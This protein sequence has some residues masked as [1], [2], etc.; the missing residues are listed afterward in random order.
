M[1]REQPSNESLGFVVGP[2]LEF[3][4]FDSGLGEYLSAKFEPSRGITANLFNANKLRQFEQGEFVPRTVD[5]EGNEVGG[6]FQAPLKVLKAEALE[7][8]SKSGVAV[9]VGEDGIAEQALE[10][11]IQRRREDLL[12]QSTI[13]RY[14][15]GLG[16]KSLG[17]SAAFLG[18]A[19]DPLNVAAAF[20][21]IVGPARYSA[22][23]ARAGSGLGARAAVR[24]GVGA[25]EGAVGVAALEPLQYGAAARLQDDYTLADSLA[26]IAFGTFLGAGLHS[27]G[28]AIFDA[29]KG[30]AKLG[31]PE[32]TVIAE[33]TVPLTTNAGFRARPTQTLD[34][35]VAAS[36]R[37]DVELEPVRPTTTVQLDPRVAT[38]GSEVIPRA[39]TVERTVEPAELRLPET[40]TVA[41]VAALQRVDTPELKRA[42][43]TRLLPEAERTTT[44]TQFAEDIRNGGEP[45][46]INQRIARALKRVDEID[47][48]LPRRQLPETRAKLTAERTEL[49]NEVQSAGRRLAEL[50]VDPY[51][52]PTILERVSDETK[53]STLRAAI[54]Q[55][56]SGKPIDVEAIVKQAPTAGYRSDPVEIQAFFDRQSSPTILRSEQEEASIYGALRLKE[57]EP[58]ASLP[59]AQKFG[60]DGEADA[61]EVLRA[62]GLSEEDIEDVL[63]EA[64]AITT[65][66]G[67][68]AKAAELAA[69]ICEVF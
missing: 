28:G 23:L 11:L 33:D 31:A 7:R 4:E 18:E 5:D 53:A 3:E 48:V 27:A 17:L 39:A 46:Y 24:A 47:R 55:D 68:L 54:A 21:P 15:G 26:N 62:R 22:M 49:V 43:E 10:L 50:G 32:R 36:A 1:A 34:E 20:V 60:A 66:G 63:R 19:V 52:P 9:E 56:L 29:V 51:S 58:A 59:T 13:E 37:T 44:E 38:F 6:F 61:I 40:R 25:V 57:P 45:D 64:D 12:R 65:Y 42:V 14:R 67:R 41:D 69:R 30:R 8:A 16:G 2:E 35:V